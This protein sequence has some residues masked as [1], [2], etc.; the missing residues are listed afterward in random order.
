MT[1]PL[2]ERGVRSYD[3][4]QRQKLAAQD[5]LTTLIELDPAG[6]SIE[7]VGS[8]ID[9][10]PIEKDNSNLIERM[11]DPSI[12]IVSLTVTESGYY[13]D[14]VSKQFDVSDP[15]IQHDVAH[16]EAPMTAFGAI[17]AA[18]KMRRA[19]GAGPFTVQ[20]CDNLQGQ[21]QFAETNGGVA[22]PFDRPGTGRMD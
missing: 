4:A 12:R 21:W 10:V 3:E 17:V 14:P 8:M 16:P 22:G 20:S 11:T 13:I 15:D 2:S 1:G 6:Q 7:V 5:Y 19:S 18:L 9:Y